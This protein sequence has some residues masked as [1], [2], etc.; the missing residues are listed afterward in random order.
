MVRS[1]HVQ[2]LCADDLVSDLL[3]GRAIDGFVEREPDGLD[4]QR[5]VQGLLAEEG[6]LREKFFEQV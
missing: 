4:L 3:H 5:L 2:P 1:L 6:A